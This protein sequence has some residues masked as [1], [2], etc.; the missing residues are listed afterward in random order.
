MNDDDREIAYIVGVSS[1]D[2]MVGADD[3]ITER[4][5]DCGAPVYFEAAVRAD[6]IAFHGDDADI[7]PVCRACVEHHS[8]DGA[9]ILSE[10]QIRELQ[11]K[12]T[13]AQDITILAAAVAVGGPRFDTVLVE[14]ATNPTGEVAQRVKEQVIGLYPT[15]VAIL[16][17]N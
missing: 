11:A 4:C 12:G 1:A 16:R 6:A 17:S 5:G 10:R 8:P 9:M 15:I 2:E 13:S 3:P 14:I 7:R